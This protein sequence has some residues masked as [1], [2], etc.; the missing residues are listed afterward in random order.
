MKSYFDYLFDV[1]SNGSVHCID[2]NTCIFDIYSISTELFNIGTK[3]KP[4][5][6][7]ISKDVTPEERREI[8]KILIKYSKVFAWTYEGIP[9]I[10]RDIAQHYIPTKEGNKPVKQ[11]MRRLRLKWPQLVEENIEKQIKAKFLEVVDYP[12]WLV[13]FVSVLKKDGRV[14][15]CVDYRDL[16]KACSKD[17]I[18]LPHIDVLIDNVAACV[19]YSFMDGFSGYNKILM[20]IIDK[21]KTSFIT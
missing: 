9:N 20:A 21:A 16:N 11:K 17:D 13:N 1:F 4:R 12:E 19:I 18:P 8:E 6:L 3:N 7:H 10:D 5:I 15:I 14:R 2:Q